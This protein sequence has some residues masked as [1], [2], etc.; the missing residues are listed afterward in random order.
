MKNN[1]VNI[2]SHKGGKGLPPKDGEGYIIDLE[3]EESLLDLFAVL[4]D[5]Y[6]DDP[7]PVDTP[8]FGQDPEAP[9]PKPIEIMEKLNEYVIGQKDA[10]RILSIAVYNHYKRITSDPELNLKKTNIMLVGPTGSGKTLLAQ[11]IAKTLDVP[12]AICDATALT[13]TGYVGGDVEDCLEKLYMV[14]GEQQ[15]LAERGIIFIDEVDKL[16]SR[17]NANGKK[18]VAGEGVQQGLLKLMEG[19]E[20]TFK[21]GSGHSQRKITLDTSN[22][23]F[24]VGGAFAGIEEV[25]EDR[26]KPDAN[27]IGFSATVTSPT[28]RKQAQVKDVTIDDLK[29]FG[30]IP[31][32]LGRIPTIAKLE[33]LDA[34]ALR[35]ILT[36]PKDSIVSHYEKMISLDGSTLKFTE[37]TLKAVAR[38]ALKNGTGARGLQTI[39]ENKLLD[40]MFNA[41]EGKDYEI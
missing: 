8:R 4:A 39:L 25:V 34:K 30:M 21:V 9:F 10:K 36:E 24:I 16:R 1:I 5:I 2:K 31:E 18:D 20:A 41:E 15:E 32:L 14:A 3:G 27:G 19:H 17:V 6:S 7:T 13:E 35:R 38:E 33:A 12:L 37:K 11:T 22:I 29:K 40:V 28:K 23:L 26:Q